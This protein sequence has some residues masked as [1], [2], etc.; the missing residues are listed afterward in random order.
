MKQ[1]VNWRRSLDEL[2]IKNQLRQ[3]LKTKGFE[4]IEDIHVQRCDFAVRHS[5]FA[6]N[7]FFKLFTVGKDLIEHWI[8]VQEEVR[9][10][11][12]LHTEILNRYNTYLVFLLPIEELPTNRDIQPIISNEY[13]CRKLIVPIED[14]NI[15]KSLTRLPFFPFEIPELPKEVMPQNVV[16][17]LVDSGF[18]SELIEDLAGRVSERTIVRK[19]KGSL[20][21]HREYK[22]PKSPKEIPLE[23]YFHRQAIIK[24]I[25]I[26]NFRGIGKELNLDTDADII[27]IYGP[28]GT[29]KTSIID[30]IEWTITGEVE[31]LWGRNYNELV[32]ANESLVN[33][34]SK[35]R[36]AE[37][38]VEFDKDGESILEKRYIDLSKSRRSYAEINNRRANDKTMIREIVGIRMPQVDVRRLRKIFLRS[39]FLGQSTI[40]E[41]ITQNPESRYDAFSHMVGTQDYMLFNEKINSVIRALERELE[42]K[43]KHKNESKEEIGN[44]S[45]RV[46]AKKQALE[47]LKRGIEEEVSTQTLMG[48]IQILLRELN[49]EV[50]KFLFPRKKGL[51]GIEELDKII[52][53][54]ST[55]PPRSSNKINALSNLLI[56]AKSEEIRTRE[57]E[58]VISNMDGLSK[59][60]NEL[61]NQYKGKEST[62]NVL[63]KELRGYSRQKESYDE[64]IVNIKWLIETLPKYRRT[65]EALAEERK[66]IKKLSKERDSIQTK[67]KAYKEKLS[68]VTKSLQKFHKGIEDIDPTIKY[69]L[70]IKEYLPV[71]KENLRKI[72]QITDSIQQ[73]NNETTQLQQKKSELEGKLKYTTDKL[74]SIE[75]KLDTE[76]EKQNRK[77]QLITKLKEYLDSPECPFCGHDWEK[78]EDL[79]K[80]VEK[81]LLHLAS[82]LH[83][84]GHYGLGKI[85]D[86]KPILKSLLDLASKH[87]TLLKKANQSKRQIK[88]LIEDI[89]LRLKKVQQLESEKVQL[90]KIFEDWKNTITYLKDK[91]PELEVQI[92]PDQSQV[93]VLLKGY[94]TQLDA[95]KVSHEEAKKKAS[96][97]D[98][99]IK[100]IKNRQKEIEEQIISH[101]KKESYYIETLT[102]LNEE[103]TEREVVNL[104][105]QN[106]STLHISIEKLLWKIKA[107]RKEINNRQSECGKIE[108]R[109]SDIENNLKKLSEKRHS[110]AERLKELK[111]ALETFRTNLQK[112]EILPS[113]K[114][115]EIINEI[116]NKKERE[117]KYFRNC[118]HL[119]TVS[120]QLKTIMILSQIK[121][122][123]NRMQ[124][125]KTEKEKIFDDITADFQ[126][127]SNW[128]ASLKKLKK[129]AEDKRKEQERSHFKMYSPATNL[130]YSRLNAHPLFN[131]IILKVGEKELKVLAQLSKCEQLSFEKINQISPRQ[132]FSEAQLNIAA[133]SIFLATALHQKWSGFNTIIIDDPVQNMD[134]F[135]VYAFLDL[136]RGLIMNGHQFILTTCNRD[137]YKLML[138]KFRDLNEA[139]R[140]QFKAYRLKGIYPEGPELIRD[141]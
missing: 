46:N 126:N 82:M 91:H 138:V 63:Q 59:N 31:R 27:V 139:N 6:L 115:Q 24:K 140:N 30:A 92:I 51:P 36:L 85:E 94:Q 119:Q 52:E 93:L 86:F 109:L 14:K 72:S 122:E 87:E 8:E 1:E 103:I 2:E 128:A 10:N 7:G 101:Q 107:M 55:Y 15:Q 132:F 131:Q 127:L 123:L 49:I 42:V 98:K 134:D 102:Q 117:I 112:E 48:E 61:Q 53:I 89:E 9:E 67:A 106:V 104:V 68:E 80:Q 37:V 74:R 35:E 47:K 97:L 81:R 96:D 108:A 141:C 44:I 69:L 70:Q 12:K 78:V 32:N 111:D 60:I 3:T 56:E 16:E 105:S 29:G 113:K 11:I 19:I 137:L 133:L 116:E 71:W 84:L 13:V 75:S 90:N 135:N 34:F 39:H 110:L 129:F 40:L 124:E 130:V 18:P 54:V 99:E 21:R 76:K 5:K 66:H 62:L 120:K 88:V 83:D 79:S 50:P 114:L 43:S 64:Q 125:E 28:N 57:I 25:R 121:Q 77:L 45:I 22:P 65:Q 17:A 23:G 26:K 73:L 100:S 38:Q 118:E 20:Y 41:F 4:F 58:K 136:V 95:I 33:L